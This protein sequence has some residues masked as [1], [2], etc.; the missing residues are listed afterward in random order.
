M[1]ICFCRKPRRKNRVGRR[2]PRWPRTRGSQR[3]GKISTN[4]TRALPL[5]RSI[6]VFRLLVSATRPSFL[7]F[8]LFVSLCVFSSLQATNGRII[9]LN[10]CWKHE[11]RHFKL[12]TV[13]ASN[14]KCD[15]SWKSSLWIIQAFIS[16]SYMWFVSVLSYCYV[17]SMFPTFNVHHIL[18]WTQNKLLICL[19]SLVKESF[20]LSHQRGIASYLCLNHCFVDLCVKF[21]VYFVFVL[22]ISI[23]VWESLV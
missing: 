11:F 7:S 6:F 14:L 23:S 3:P 19:H 15:Q 21:C 22:H 5:H 13:F 20:Q 1:A 2:F 12:N 9:Y 4:S 18:D 17:V 10:V 16:A 8:S